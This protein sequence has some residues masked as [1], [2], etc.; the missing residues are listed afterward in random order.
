MTKA[1][2]CPRPGRRDHY[3]ESGHDAGV[4]RNEEQSRLALRE[5][6]LYTGDMGRLDDEGYLYFVDRKKDVIR[7]AAK[8]LLPGG[9]GCDQASPRHPGLRRYCRTFRVGRR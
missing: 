6:W 2:L 3:Q 4:L 5:G 8:H 9:G 7:R 1:I